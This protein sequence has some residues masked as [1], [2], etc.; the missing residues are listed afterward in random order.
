MAL[1]SASVAP[2]SSSKRRFNQL[3]SRCSIASADVLEWCPELLPPAV[4]FR[5]CEIGQGSWLH[6]KQA[7]T[8][9]KI[10]QLLELEPLHLFN[11]SSHNKHL[12]RGGL[13]QLKY[14]YLYIINIYNKAVICH[15]AI[16]NCNVI[17]I[18]H[19]HLCLRLRQWTL[20]SSTK[21]SQKAFQLNP[22]PRELLQTSA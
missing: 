7:N 8:D 11:V 6:V 5:I 21:F 9:A 12:S 3:S 15:Y 19:L 20:R 14:D 17:L 13:S 4:F 18:I 10:S 1:S 2:T 22:A 16:T